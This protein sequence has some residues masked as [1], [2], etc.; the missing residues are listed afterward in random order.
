MHKK[1]MTGQDNILD[2]SDSRV[3]NIV[4]Y[5]QGMLD[6]LGLFVQKEWHRQYCIIDILDLSIEDKNIIIQERS[7]GTASKLEQT[8]DFVAGNVEGL[9]L[10]YFDECCSVLPRESRNEQVEETWKYVIWRIAEYI[11]FI[12]QPE[13]VKSCFVEKSIIKSQ[14]TKKDGVFY[15]LTIDSAYLV[16]IKIQDVKTPQDEIDE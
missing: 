6:T 2:Y 10:K 11:M 15:C 13:Y 4:G 1:K 8:N 12:E 9:L 14:S 16:L 3:P 5:I 7:D